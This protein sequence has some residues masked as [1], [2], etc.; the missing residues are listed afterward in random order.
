VF[1]SRTRLDRDTMIM[2]IRIRI[3]MMYVW[4]IEIPMGIYS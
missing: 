4:E 1:G 3:S 2:D